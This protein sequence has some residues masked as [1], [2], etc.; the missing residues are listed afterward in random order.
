MG[1][2]IAKPTVVEPKTLFQATLM[3]PSTRLNEKAPTRNKVDGTIIDLTQDGSDG[4]SSPSNQN[5]LFDA[6][7]VANRAA[8]RA[9]R[10]GKARTSLEKASEAAFLA[11]F[12][13]IQKGVAIHLDYTERNREEKRRLLED[14]YI[15]VQHE[16]QISKLVNA[17]HNCDDWDDILKD[18]IP[19]LETKCRGIRLALEALYDVDE[20]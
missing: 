13:R 9:K 20:Y 7:A 10:K 17:C 12:P 15:A 2:Y 5:E 16:I 6:L 14:E 8:F 1:S 11:A 3:Q 18:S 4:P 19:R